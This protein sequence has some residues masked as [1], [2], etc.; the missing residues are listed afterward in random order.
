MKTINASSSISWGASDAWLESYAGTHRLIYKILPQAPWEQSYEDAGLSQLALI[1]AN[2][3]MEIALGQL[4]APLLR[5]TGEYSKSKFEEAGYR[6]LLSN[7]VP[8]LTGVTIPIDSEPFKSTEL[9]RDRRNATIHKS[10]AIAS[11]DIAQ[12]ALYSAVHGCIALYDHLGE[13]FPYQEALRE[14]PLR[15]APWFSEIDLP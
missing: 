6:R 4:L 8:E 10:S 9:L 15:D 1:G 11:V 5:S 7:W 2:H 3:L 12:S 14:Y 13:D